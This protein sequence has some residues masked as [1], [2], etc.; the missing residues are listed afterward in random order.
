MD[1]FYGRREDLNL[2]SISDIIASIIVKLEEHDF[3]FIKFSAKRVFPIPEKNHGKK[4]IKV[5]A[6]GNMKKR[7]E[8]L[9]IFTNDELQMILFNLKSDLQISQE[10]P[11]FEVQLYPGMQKTLLEFSN[12]DRKLYVVDYWRC[13]TYCTEKIEIYL[14]LYKNDPWIASRLK[15][16][17]LISENLLTEE[18]KQE[19][20]SCT[21]A[22][23]IFYI[24]NQEQNSNLSIFEIEPENKYSA[25]I[26]QYRKVV[27]FEPYLDEET[28]SGDYSKLINKFTGNKSSRWKWLSVTKNRY[29]KLF[30]IISEKFNEINEFI[31]N[32]K[33]NSLKFIYQLT[34]YGPYDLNHNCRLSLSYKKFKNYSPIVKSLNSYFSQIMPQSSIDLY[35]NNYIQDLCERTTKC[36][37]CFQE[38]TEDDTQYLCI[39]C[40]PKH[41]HCQKC[42][43]KKYDGEGLM[44]FAHPHYLYL[45]T[46]ESRRFHKLTSGKFS[47][48]NVSK[49]IKDGSRLHSNVECDNKS[50]HMCESNGVIQ[51]TRYLCAHCHNFD[52]CER[53][54]KKWIEEKPVD[55]IEALKKKGHEKWHVFIVIEYPLYY[56]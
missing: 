11:R 10:F 17:F 52:F 48:S 14:N 1:Y 29:F 20:E 19:I 38:L 4:K 55:M 37:L 6:L 23:I 36:S 47:F 28:L 33:S 22:E 35:F 27:A 40:E 43:Q 24:V 15:T 25:Q 30:A 44:Q 53:C 49:E 31:P 51:G 8:F 41:Y 7:G 5:L 16:V 34:A 56:V 2:D 42:H 3:R 12:D 26:I 39:E 21:C 18:I 54:M 50:I 46:S 32:F 45:I 13:E 9:R